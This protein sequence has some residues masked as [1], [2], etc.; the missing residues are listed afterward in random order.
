[1][2]IKFA[3]GTTKS[4]ITNRLNSRITKRSDAKRRDIEPNVI[5]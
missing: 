4:S 5:N 1:M 2:G 3:V